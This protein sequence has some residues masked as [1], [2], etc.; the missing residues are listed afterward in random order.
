MLAGDLLDTIYEQATAE[1]SEILS[2]E[3]VTTSLDRWSNVDNEPLICASVITSSGENYLASTIDTSGNPHNSD[4]L[5]TLAKQSVL[6]CKSK[7]NATV[8]SF[9][10]DNTANVKKM[11]EKLSESDKSQEIIYYGCSAHVLNLLAKDLKVP[12]LTE[13]VVKY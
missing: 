1:S 12:N 4:Y 8:R 3:T 9:V 10:T 2:G 7:F 13:H 5:C 11:R 6:E